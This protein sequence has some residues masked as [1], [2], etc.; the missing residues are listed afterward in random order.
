MKQQ[1]LDTV[2]KEEEGGGENYQYILP[3]NLALKNQSEAQMLIKLK[4]RTF[5]NII[6]MN[7]N[8]TNHHHLHFLLQ[9]IISIIFFQITRSITMWT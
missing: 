5:M 1:I 6:M 2:Y 4:K 8:T 7:R 3:R 9:I